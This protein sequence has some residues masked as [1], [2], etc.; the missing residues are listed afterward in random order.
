MSFKEELDDPEYVGDL[1][2]QMQNFA[3]QGDPQYWKMQQTDDGRFAF[4]NDPPSRQRDEFKEL[5]ANHAK[6]SEHIGLALWANKT[7]EGD[8]VDERFTIDNAVQLAKSIDC[9]DLFDDRSQDNI[10]ERQAMSGVAFVAAAHA[11]IEQL[12]GSFLEWV[13]D[14]LQRAATGPEG[15]NLFGVRSSH[16]LMHPAVFAAHGFSQLLARGV[17]PAV[18]IEAL[19]SLAVDAML[20]VQAA[21]F[22][23]AKAYA[24][25]RPEIIWALLRLGLQQCIYNE[26]DGPD[27]YSIAWDEREAERKLALI[28]EAAKSIAERA[29]ATLPTPPVPWIKGSGAVRRA[30]R[31]TKGY[32]RN[33][34][35][36]HHQDAEKTILHLPLDV[37]LSSSCK[38][39][40]LVLL[41]QL[42]D[43][44]I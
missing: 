22:S 13:L 40:F 39:E 11:P 37:L 1:S 14:V 2:K 6:L 5:T 4:F 26:G 20:E 7:L 35:W 18:C 36:F 16:L 8:T 21:V 24:S 9:P 28:D 41:G 25:A 23:G 32:I 34:V 30:A 33:P 10:S 19:L 44:M 15:A 27:V 12:D 17:A 38:P 29:F 42:V 43:A 3:D 31:D